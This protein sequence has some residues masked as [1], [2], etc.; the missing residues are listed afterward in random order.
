MI[1]VR[2][3]YKVKLLCGLQPVEYYSSV[4]DCSY[5]AK[6]T[7]QV[8]MVQTRVAH[9]VLSGVTIARTVCL[10]RFHHFLGWKT[11]Q[12]LRWGKGLGGPGPPLFENK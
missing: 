2:K 6:N 11:L 3:V 4:W 1:L 5:T 10:I 7:T 12:G 8:E 9:R